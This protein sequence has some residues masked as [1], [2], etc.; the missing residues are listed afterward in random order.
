VQYAI[1]YFTAPCV[2][3]FQVLLGEV[4]DCTEWRVS[5]KL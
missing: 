5:T 2:R 1:L 3:I 4:N